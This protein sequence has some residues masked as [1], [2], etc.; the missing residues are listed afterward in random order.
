[1]ATALAVLDALGRVRVFRL[2]GL[3]LI[4]ALVVY[5]ALCA[6]IGFWAGHVAQNRGRQFSLYF[7]TAFVV[8]LCGLI[9]GIIVVIVAYAQGPA[10]APP[11]Q[12]PGAPGTP[13]PGLYAPSPPPGPATP[14]PPPPTGASAPPPSGADSGGEVKRDPDGGVEYTPPPPPPK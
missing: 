2:R 7:V 9:P 11:G 1:M 10:A 3:G 12:M 5:L 8:S 13:T 4:G 14:P 6:L